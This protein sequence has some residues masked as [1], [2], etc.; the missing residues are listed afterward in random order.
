MRGALRLLQ[1]MDVRARLQAEF[2]REVAA[3]EASVLLRL[4]RA[5]SS[6][7][8]IGDLVALL[9]APH[10]AC[11]QAC[12]AVEL[13]REPPPLRFDPPG[14][15]LLQ[16]LFAALQ[17][18]E[19]PL[20][21]SAL[22]K[23]AGCPP[24]Q[25]GERI[26]ALIAVG[27]V[28]AV[29]RAPELRCFTVADAQSKPRAAVLVLAALVLTILRASG[30]KLKLMELLAATR[31]SEERVR[32]AIQH[33]QRAQQVTCTGQN[34]GTR[35]GLPDETTQRATVMAARPDAPT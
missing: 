2:E 9:E 32:R 34:S 28:A 35:Y 22:C 31:C 10:G 13:R 25:F 4:I 3:S 8:T 12:P 23:A 6:E 21:A 1:V 24:A 29:D 19:Q 30:R 14:E 27:L 16:A 20:T 33:L 7:L 18:A 15:H 26:D 17:R 5:R 11:L